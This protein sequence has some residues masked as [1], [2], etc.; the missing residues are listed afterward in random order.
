MRPTEVRERGRLTG[1]LYE[2]REKMRSLLRGA[3]D[4][5]RSRG[6]HVENAVAMGYC[7]G[8]TAVLELARSGADL[9]G[10]APLL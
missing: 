3:L 4:A 10:F 2:N 6:A 9:T 7:F 1:A 5:A 8:G